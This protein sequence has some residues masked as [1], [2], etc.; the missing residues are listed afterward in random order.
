MNRVLADYIDHV[1]VF[2]AIRL[3]R[4]IKPEHMK[5][6]AVDREILDRLFDAANWAPSHG[7]TEPWRF[8]VFQ[9]DARKDLAEAMCRTM[10]E[11]G[12][13]T[14]PDDDPRR[15]KIQ[16]KLETAPVVAVIVCAPSTKAN[17]V[18][19][20]EIEA[21]AM[22]VQNLHL[23]ARAE[24]LAGF[25]SSGKKAFHPAMAAFLGLEPPA[26][27]LGFFFIGYPAQEWPN[28]Q[29][30]PVRDKITWIEKRA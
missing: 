9:G 20:E 26:R 16:R 17:I 3:R 23:A 18:E 13:D 28:G 7:L 11:D 14:L 27:C 8:I 24:G 4:S 6:D 21:T 2:D 15:A 29:R 10:V 19:L 30:R 25:W 1:D 5:P 12:Q 22:A